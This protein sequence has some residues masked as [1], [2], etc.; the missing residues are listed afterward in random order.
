M[1]FVLRVLAGGAVS[2]IAVS[3]WLFMTVFFISM[4]ISVAKRLSEFNYLGK[5]KAILH[6]SSQSGYS[7]AYLTSMLWSCGAITLVVY[8]LYVVEQGGIVVYSVLPATY[9]IFRFIYLA[10]L[11]K[12]G[13]PVKVLF[14]DLQLLITALFFLIFIGI[15]IYVPV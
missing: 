9:G 8:A 5:E 13:D 1:G 6:R 11:G 14:T 4:L 15:T 12:A 2:S 3:S 7:I 10:D